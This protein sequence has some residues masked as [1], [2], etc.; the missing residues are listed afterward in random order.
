MSRKKR[1]IIMAIEEEVLQ[2]GNQGMIMQLFNNKIK[3]DGLSHL[4][5]RK[6]II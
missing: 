2:V 4:L 1:I 6:K 5:R 3:K